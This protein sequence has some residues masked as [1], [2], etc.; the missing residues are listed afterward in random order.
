MIEWIGGFLQNQ[1]MQMGFTRKW[2]KW[3]M[4]CV[5]I[6][7]YSINFNGTQVGPISPKRGLRQGD[8][9]SPYLFLFCVE[10]LSCAIQKAAGE[11]KIHGCQINGHAPSV[12][13]LLFAD[14]S[15]VFCKVTIEDVRE[16]KVVLQKYAVYLGY[17]SLKI[18]Y[19]F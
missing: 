19:L 6:V 11:G 9:L 10:G 16:I 5:T 13:H 15:F 1:M 8:P 14:D 12:T 4:L 17:K 3:V 7:S 2:I 18:W